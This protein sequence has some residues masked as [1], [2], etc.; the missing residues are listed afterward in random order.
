MSLDLDRRHVRLHGS[1]NLRDIGGYPTTCG[2]QVKWGHIFRSGALWGLS[3]D[4]WAWMEER[5]FAAICDLRSDAERAITPTRWRGDIAPRQVDHIYDAAQLFGGRRVERAAGIGA[6]EGELY[7]RF[8]RLLAPSFR[9]LFHALLEG[10]A[11]ALVH[12]TAGQDRTGLAVGLLLTAL[13]V[14]RATIHADYL[15][16]TD[17]RRPEHEM[18]RSQLAALAD[19]N[20]V[21]AF[22]S[23]MLARHGVDAFKPKRL[24]D[25]RGRPFLEIA[26]SAIAHEWGSIDAYLGTELRIGKAERTALQDRLL[27]RG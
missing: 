13:G 8:A 17:L 5:R 14:D 15:L 18:D 26:F 19:H 23:N 7:I 10:D 25:D 6:L 16:S 3:E 12:C 2:R 24:V 9:G 20:V 11:P 4:D 22:Y 27:A 21:A 1:S